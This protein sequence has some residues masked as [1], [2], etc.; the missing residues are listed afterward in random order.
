VLAPRVVLDRDPKA[1]LRGL[2]TIPQVALI[3]DPCIECGFC[4]PVCPS[5]DL[6]TSPRQR[7]ALRR[8][9]LRQPIDASS[10]SPS[11]PKSVLD[12]LV[13]DYGYDAVDTC[14]GD[15]TC[16]LACPVGI[17]TGE[18]MK[19]FRHERHTRREERVAERTAAH[20]G[21]LERGARLALGAAQKL[22]DGL[23]TGTTHLLR[24]AVNPD[25]VPEWLPGTPGP[26]RGPVPETRR[27]GAAAVY[28]TACVNRIFGP[29]GTPEDGDGSVTAAVVALSER[30]GR[31]VWLPG[32]LTGSCCATIWHSKGYERG[33]TLMANRTIEQAWDWT[34]G[35]K[36]PLIVDASSCTLGLLREVLP[37]LT[38]ENRERHDKLEILD[39]VQWADR[40]L[41]PRLTVHRRRASMVVH[42]TCS[43][44][45]LD[46]VDVL[47]RLAEACAER[48]D[49][50]VW[51][52]C[53]GF[54]GDR[55]FLHKELTESAT[56]RERDE[57]AQNTY[58][59]YVSA[60]RTCELGMEHATGRP[61][62]SVL[63]D[64]EWATRAK[65][66]S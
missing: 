15:S 53:C 1:H 49:V 46:L 18:W 35:G 36:L 25:L 50:P 47:R 56:A 16:A 54:A 13:A 29:S 31:P 5:H 22:P 43:T 11:K 12:E 66:T 14:A 34:D 45:H 21:A 58:E 42:P 64:L 39:A 41:L 2:K 63:V 51:A 37:Y 61:F 17:D 3:A 19:E 27:A 44:R 38:D 28:F 59:A 33:N 10:G 55:G 57:I 7:I 48:V 6:T 65:I 52:E 24:S 60:N 30:A 40:E 26:A 9:M 20:F 32:D 4:E 62:R 23:L 8:E